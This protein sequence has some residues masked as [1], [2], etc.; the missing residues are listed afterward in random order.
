MA[1]SY[2]KN[3]RSHRG[4]FYFQILYLW[5]I[6]KYCNGTM[7][8]STS[9]FNISEIC[10]DS[11]WLMGVQTHSSYW[12]FQGQAPSPSTTQN[13][14][15]WPSAAPSC[16]FVYWHQC[17]AL[18]SV[19]FP[20]HRRSGGRLATTLVATK[21]TLLPSSTPTSTNLNL[22]WVEVSLFSFYPTTHP[23]PIHPNL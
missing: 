20:V 6:S 13:N 22:N 5:S 18:H 8:N 1:A 19:G 12:L 21:T 2:L 16:L 14:H 9:N 3:I 7:P 17:S 10:D 15:S 23:Q 11:G 4:H